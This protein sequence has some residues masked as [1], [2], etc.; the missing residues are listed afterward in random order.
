[1]GYFATAPSPYTFG[2][3]GNFDTGFFSWNEIPGVN[4]PIDPPIY[5]AGVGYYGLP[6]LERYQEVLVATVY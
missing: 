3:T 1:M 4:A 2:E 6:I 5:K